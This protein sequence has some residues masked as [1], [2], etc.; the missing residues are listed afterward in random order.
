VNFTLAC[1]ENFVPSG[2]KLKND[3]GLRS[4]IEKAALAWSLSE[5]SS[6]LMSKKKFYKK[7]RKQNHTL[8]TMLTG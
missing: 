1:R 4:P 7:V 2:F 8:S 5:E 6:L 3:P